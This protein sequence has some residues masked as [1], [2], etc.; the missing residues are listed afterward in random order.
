MSAVVI[1][2]MDYKEFL[3]ELE[4]L[5]KNKDILSFAKWTTENVKSDFLVKTGCQI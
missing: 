2:L 4:K 5:E 3:S 1:D